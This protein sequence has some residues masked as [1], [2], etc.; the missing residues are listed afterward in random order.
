MA[1]AVPT[2]KFEIGSGLESATGNIRAA[3]IALYEQIAADPSSPQEVARQLGIR[4][5]LAWSL[6]RVIQS[7]D[8]LEALGEMPG[9]AAVEGLLD[10]AAKRGVSEAAVGRVR[11]AVEALERI[12]EVQVDDRP[13]LDLALDGMGRD[14]E[15]SRKLAFRGNSG[16]CGLQARTRLIC[17]LAVPNP[18]RPDLLDVV[19]LGGFMGLRRLRSGVQWPLFRAGGWS[20][21]NL[22]I[23]KKTWQSLP[24]SPSDDSDSPIVSDFGRGPRPE[25]RPVETEG[26]LDLVLLPGP[27]W[28]SGAFDCVR[29]EAMHQA[30]NRYATA[31]DSIGQFAVAI[32]APAEQLVFDLI[33]H[34]DL[35]FALRPRVFAFPRLFGHREPM[36]PDDDPSQLPV[37]LPV[38]D[39]PGNPP[40]VGLAAVPGYSELL[41]RVCTRM[42]WDPTTLQGVRLHMKYPPLNSTVGMRFDLPQPP[43]QR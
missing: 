3:L 41:D 20:D 19:V 4:K 13:T 40:A 15:L 17:C 34:K 39:L 7:N 8:P 28:N 38:A 27:I 30:A 10:A 2:A 12:I 43:A 24:L 22:G 37:R 11:S 18:Q 29:V 33:M 9:S 25:F 26:N 1:L 36:P 5:S 23:D 14:L 35:A 16:I 42:S 21:G 6:S 31:D 32:T